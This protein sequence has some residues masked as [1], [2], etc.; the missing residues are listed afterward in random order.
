MKD[1]F[2]CLDDNHQVHPCDAIQVLR[3]NRIINQDQV[4]SS[5]V[6]TVFLFIDHNFGDGPPL[7]FET[8][9]FGGKMD[10]YQIRCSTWEQAVIQHRRT[11]DEV[12]KKQSKWRLIIEWFQ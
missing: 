7:L 1:I 3:K 9:V 4:G 10:G 8:M 6:S 5:F 11:L 2:Y 12:K